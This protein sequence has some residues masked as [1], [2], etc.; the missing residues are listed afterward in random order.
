MTLII[1]LTLIFN[2]NTEAQKLNM[3]YEIDQLL[4]ASSIQYENNVLGKKVIR[5]QIHLMSPIILNTPMHWGENDLKK[6]EESEYSHHNRIDL[7]K[8][9]FAKGN[10]KKSFKVAK[11]NLATG[12]DKGQT[13][14][15]M[16]M[17][18]LEF[19]KIEQAKFWFNQALVINQCDYFANWKLAELEL[20]EGNIEKA[21]KLGIRSHVLNRNNLQI[22][23][24]LEEV[25][26][27][28]GGKYL[29]WSFNPQYELERGE[30]GSISINANEEPWINY[31][32]CKAMWTYEK[33][34][35][36]TKTSDPERNTIIQEKECLLSGLI[37]YEHSKQKLPEYEA[38][39]E[40]IDHNMI[41]VYILYE[42]IL[43]NSPLEAY[44]LTIEEIDGMTDYI[45]EVRLH[46]P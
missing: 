1:L 5:E 22:L 12:E 27:R 28:K 29:H 18:S 35:A 8:A 4:E 13:Y 19:G 24:F 23:Q 7:A 41:D 25:T 16:G 43:V 20:K 6:I 30:G 31:G 14:D 21:L 15:L 37:G 44:A 36:L 39:K 10:L 3:P 46:Y 33:D 34:Y 45:F 26:N 32:K 40:A 2:V 9:Y 38:L 17:I 11:E 42:I